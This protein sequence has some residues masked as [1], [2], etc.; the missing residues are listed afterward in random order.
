MSVK[1]RLTRVGKKKQPSYRLVVM[2][3]RKPRDGAYIEQ[4]GRYDPR[5]DPSLVEID[6]AAAMKW[7]QRGAQPTDRARKLLEISGAWSQF[8]VAKGDIH[9]I[10]DAVS[11]APVIQ[12]PVVEPEIHVIE[13]SAEPEIHVVESPTDSEAPAPDAVPDFV[14]LES[15]DDAVA[16]ESAKDEE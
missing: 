7:L 1:I 9:T 8:R 4:I 14:L 12:P 6:N 13:A 5:Q 10:S 16:D 3:S 15:P 11:Q 2:D